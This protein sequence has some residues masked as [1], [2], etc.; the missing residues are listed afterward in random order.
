MRLI[1]ITVAAMAMMLMSLG[2]YAQTPQ[3]AAA[4]LQE[5]VEKANAKDMIAAAKLL[6][7]ALAM[8]EQA[9]DEGAEVVMEAK[10]LMPQVYY[11][12]GGSLVQQKPE[13][14]IVYF[15]KAVKVAEE[16]ENV[17]VLT[18]AKGWVAKTYV[19]MGANA[20]NNKDYAAAAEIFQ[21][22]YDVNPN[23]PELS[24]FL[25]QSYGELGEY[26][27]A[28]NTFKGVLALEEHGEKYKKEVDNAKDRVIYYMLVN[29]SDVAPAQP[30]VAIQ[31]LTN[32]VAIEPAPQAYLLLLQTA[33]NSKNY[34][35][36]IEFGDK[37][38]EAQ[39]DAEHK[40]TAN[41]FVGAAYDNKGDQTKALGYYRKVTAGPYVA[42]AKTQIAAIQAAQQ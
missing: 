21:K 41:F 16:T 42:N 3:E 40:S 8:G 32:A 35:S 26:E 6:E 10:K 30:A 19:M 38:I 24:L 7:E 36:V 37:A 9:G 18:R 13:E 12:A 29:A 25:A 28:Y 11:M 5:A 17:G 1:K 22:G 20:F 31:L 27:K 15:E 4:K 33:N 2:V 14:A 23:D 34:N 39:T